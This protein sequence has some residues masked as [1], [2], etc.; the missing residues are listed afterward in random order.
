[1]TLFEQIMQDQIETAERVF[2]E[3]IEAFMSW[4]TSH[5]QGD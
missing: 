4:Y 5:G 1:M 2:Q 3:K